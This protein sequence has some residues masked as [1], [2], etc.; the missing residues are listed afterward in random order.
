M[1]KFQCV[2]TRIDEYVVEIDETII[3]QEF[4]DN[5]SRYFW[6]LDG[7]EDIA[8]QMARHQLLHGDSVIYMEGL[9][10]VKRD[11]KLPWHSQD[12]EGFTPGLNIN[13]ICEGDDIEAD[14]TLIKDVTVPEGKKGEEPL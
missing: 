14:I 9:G 2:V 10:N 7:L 1:K 8:S 13:I 12:K 11:G 5:F 6:K 3:N 4:I